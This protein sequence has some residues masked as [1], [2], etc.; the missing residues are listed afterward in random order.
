MHHSQRRTD[1][2]GGLTVTIFSTAALLVTVWGGT[3]Y[4]W[5]SGQILG[6]I[7]VAA[8]S[9]AGYLL[10]QRRAADPITPLHLFRRA[11]TDH[12]LAGERTSGA[13]STQP[14][15]RPLSRPRQDPY[16]GFLGGSDMGEADSTMQLTRTA[17]P[18]VGD[19]RFMGVAGPAR[20]ATGAGSDRACSAV[21]GAPDVLP[22]LTWERVEGCR[23]SVADSD[24]TQGPALP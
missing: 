21:E 16:G 2:A 8:I 19:P 24:G 4:R 22:I 11:H 10:I 7:A 17:K 20:A 6:L 13:I 15:A 3:R 9:L 18:P 5:G 14:P 23:L 1:L 12:D